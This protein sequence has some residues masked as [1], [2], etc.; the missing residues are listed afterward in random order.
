VA[1]RP[2]RAN[3]RSHRAR[4]GGCR[5][6]SRCEP[7]SQVG[8]LP[9]PPAAFR[10]F[11]RASQFPLRLR[12]C[13]HPTGGRPAGLWRWASRP[14]ERPLPRLTPT[15][16]PP[17]SVTSRHPRPQTDAVLGDPN[18][19]GRPRP[20]ADAAHPSLNLAQWKRPLPTNRRAPPSLADPDHPELMLLRVGEFDGL[21]RAQKDRTTAC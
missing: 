8:S 14:V 16:T 18:A 13:G 10:V 4:S 12:W 11:A 20:T 7:Y 5:R 15:L 2:W 19:P 9:G 21:V 3:C 6:S 17:P 1:S